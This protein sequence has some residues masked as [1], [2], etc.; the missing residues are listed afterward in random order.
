M[1]IGQ[2][3]RILRQN[4]AYH[5]VLTG[6]TVKGGTKMLIFGGIRVDLGTRSMV[7]TVLACQ[8][9]EDR[10]CYEACPKKDSAM[11]VDPETGV[12]YVDE[13]NCVGCGKCMRACRFTPSRISMKRDRDRRNWKA[14]KCDLCRGNPD[15]PQ[16]IR[17][18]PVQCLG[19]SGSSVMLPDGVRPEDR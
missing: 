3:V 2:P 5:T 19:M 7:H 13:E 1:R 17:W 16:C 10:P 15:G 18:C 8:Q 12:V 14:V 11:C 6:Y 4:T 9:C